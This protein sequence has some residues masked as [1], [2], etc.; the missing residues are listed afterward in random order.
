MPYLIANDYKTLIQVDNLNQIVGN[1]TTLITKIEEHAESEIKSYLVHKYALS[2]EFTNT[3]LYKPEVIRYAKDRFYLDATAYSASST[4]ALNTL[5]LYQGNVYIN[6][7][8]IVVAEA[9]NATKWQ[10]LGAQYSIYFA[11]LPANEFDYSTEYVKDDEVFYNNK[12]YTA[13]QDSVG[14]LPT[15]STSIWGAGVAYSVD[16]DILPT[17]PTN[18]TKGDNRNAQ[19]VSFFIDVVLYHLHSRIAPRNIP[20]LRVKRY[21]DAIRWLK[22]VSKGNH[23][24]ADIPLIQPTQGLST[25]WGNPSTFTRSNNNY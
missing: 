16:S 19:M 9:F 17:D 20:D 11:T 21:D 2:N 7:I 25:I 12:V 15:S 24:T 6:I 5:C 1:D 23:V 13:L 22:E 3:A 8:A 10:N 18:Y 14:I 4:Y